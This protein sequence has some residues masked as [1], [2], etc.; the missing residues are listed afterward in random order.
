MIITARQITI[1]LSDNV[2]NISAIPFIYSHPY[3][4]AIAIESMIKKYLTFS[5]ASIPSI[6]E[7]PASLFTAL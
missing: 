6:N 3:Q 7:I 1:L 4:I 5:P 2:W